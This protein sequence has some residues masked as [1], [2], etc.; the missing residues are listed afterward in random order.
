[1]SQSLS[2]SVTTLSPLG[3]V[4]YTIEFEEWFFSFSLISSFEIEVVCFATLLYFIVFSSIQSQLQ[5][6]EKSISVEDSA[7]VIT[8][9]LCSK[10]SLLKELTRGNKFYLSSS[11][12]LK[13]QREDNNL[14]KTCQENCEAKC[15]NY[16]QRS[17]R[18]KDPDVCSRRSFILS[19][20]LENDI[21]I[22][23]DCNNEQELQIF[24]TM[25]KQTLGAVAVS[26]N[27]GGFHHQS[28][29][30]ANGS[31]FL[32][33]HAFS[34]QSSWSEHLFAFI[35]LWCFF[36]LPARISFS[37]LCDYLAHPSVLCH[38]QP[39][40]VS[41]FI[42]ECPAFSLIFR[43]DTLCLPRLKSERGSES[44]EHLLHQRKSRRNLINCLPFFGYNFLS[45]HLA[46]LSSTTR[47]TKAALEKIDSNE[48][49]NDRTTYFIWRKEPLK[50]LLWIE[51]IETS[52]LLN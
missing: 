43:R 49:K 48:G 36:C 23:V 7:F 1:M 47:V 4:H 26:Y 17:F 10:R 28:R 20:C 52:S 44:P 13:C 41:L 16:C 9:K 31:L 8:S 6:G 45:V 2:V 39:L 50:S 11:E 27:C 33:C 38:H 30:R 51:K 40:L 5:F 35:S 25:T 18:S 37:C 14:K 34:W 12:F 24:L 15:K 21:S 22:D 19:V 46:S 29:K 3:F 32:A 42:K